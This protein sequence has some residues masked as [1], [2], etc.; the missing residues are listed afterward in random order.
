MDKKSLIL[1]IFCGIC[2][3]GSLQA[4]NYI[5]TKSLNQQTQTVKKETIKDSE[6]FT[7][8]TFED[9]ISFFENKES[10]ILYFG[11]TDCPWCQQAK[12]YLKKQA[13]SSDVKVHYI[14]TRED[15]EEHTRLYT[16][17]QK[18]RI[19]PY[20]KEYMEKDDENELTLYVP[21]VLNVKNGIVVDGHMGTVNGHDATQRKMNDDEKKELVKRY[22]KLFDTKGE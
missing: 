21:L 10:G 14:Q 5:N 17:E 22:K 18:E 7:S 1:S 16:D 12:P 9:A 13:K 11:F 20:I 4:V 19:L 6:I 15:D 2:V 3:L 8:M